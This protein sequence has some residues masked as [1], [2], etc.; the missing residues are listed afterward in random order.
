MR[1][2]SWLVV[3]GVGALAAATASPAAS[4]PTIRSSLDGKRVL[5]HRIHWLGFPSVAGAKVKEVDF[6]VDGKLV[7][8]EHHAPYTYGR[9]G[10]WLVTSWLRP[11]IHRFTVRVVTSDG[12]RAFDTVSARTLAPP[13]PPAALWGAWR[14]TVTQAQAGS[15]T[16]AGTWTLRIDA[17][18]WRI[19]DPRGGRNWVDVAY[20]GA[21]RLQARGGIW[22]S[23]VESSGGNGWCEDTNTPVDYTWQVS[24]RTLTVTLAGADRCGDPKN[25]QHFIWAGDWARV[26]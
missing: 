24:G 8:I 10:N 26:G 18:G 9:D 21:G 6:L 19:T 14:R 22:T 11:G 13:Q 20:T 12:A 2:R 1:N 4:K 7:W 23:P 3:A 5:P 17:S 15:Q 25:L 16:P